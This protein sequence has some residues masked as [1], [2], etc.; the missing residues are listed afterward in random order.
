MLIYEGCFSG[1]GIREESLAISHTVATF[2]GAPELVETPVW[3]YIAGI[4]SS[5]SDT[6]SDAWILSAESG[7][8]ST[9]KALALA[10]RTAGHSETVAVPAFALTQAGVSELRKGMCGSIL[11]APVCDHPGWLAKRFVMPRMFSTTWIP[12][13]GRAGTGLPSMTTARFASACLAGAR[14]KGSANGHEQCD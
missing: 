8:P 3:K 2:G 12:A 14:G 6:H 1:G 10:Q 13:A 11:C 7:R 4:D 9:E 5:N